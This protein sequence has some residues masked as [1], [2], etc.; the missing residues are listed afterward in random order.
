MYTFAVQCNRNCQIPGVI[1]RQWYLLLNVT[2]AFPFLQPQIL[3]K[4][5]QTCSSMRV[6]RTPIQET[7]ETMGRNS[8]ESTKEAC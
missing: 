3:I 4:D 5:M 8:Q 2:E 6:G 7:Y 1:I